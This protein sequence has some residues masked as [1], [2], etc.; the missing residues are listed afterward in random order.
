MARIIPT[1]QNRQFYVASGTVGSLTNIGDMTVKAM[2][3]GDNLEFY[4]V[5]KGAKTNLRSDIIKLKNL[6][7]VKAIPA[8]A[9]ARPLKKVTV[10]LNSAY[11]SDNAAIVGQDYVL[12][13]NFANFFGGGIDNTYIK[14]AVVHVNSSNSTPSSFY[15]AM[16]NALD[17]AFS[18]ELGASATSNPYLSFTA[19]STGLVIEEKE[20]DTWDKETYS[21]QSLIF[22]VQPT[23]IYTG[24]EDVV[25]GTV[26]DGTSANTNTVKNGKKTAEL[27]WFCMGERGD[28]YRKAGYPNYIPTKYLVDETAEYDYLELHF[29]FT[30]TGV[31]SYRSEK[32]ITIVA[33]VGTGDDVHANINAVIGA[34]NT[35][36]GLTLVSTL[37]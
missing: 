35:A 24:T 23:T 22:D 5:V 13:I 21:L 15:T 9:M 1:N 31:N 37:T 11:L 27:E 34:I 19:S 3:S 29:A 10:T 17:T 30:D 36:T 4:F 8:S 16:K 18:R 20:Q 2:G 32:D 14:D 12:R 26:T 7:Y 6:D 25:W 33:P 28:Q